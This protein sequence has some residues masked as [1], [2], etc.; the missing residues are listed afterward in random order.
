MDNGAVQVSASTE[1][2]AVSAVDVTSTAPLGSWIPHR[3]LHQR[4][5]E[6]YF[7]NVAVDIPISPAEKHQFNVSSFPP[8]FYIMTPN[9]SQV[10]LIESGNLLGVGEMAVG[11]LSILEEDSVTFSHHEVVTGRMRM[12]GHWQEDS[13]DQLLM[14][15]SATIDTSDQPWMT[16]DST[17]P[18]ICEKVCAHHAEKDELVTGMMVSSAEKVP[19]GSAEKVPLGSAEKV[20]L[21]SAEKVPLSS[22]EKVPLG[23]ADK[24]PLGSA[25]ENLLVVSSSIV[26]EESGSHHYGYSEMVMTTH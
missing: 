26:C 1:S 10:S 14:E 5:R 16:A 3:F 15:A 13:P 17:T 24:V 9:I 18:D 2:C 6:H 8:Q 22:A 20:P 7:E 19:L 21:G 11:H 25:D 12:G 23:S 4:G